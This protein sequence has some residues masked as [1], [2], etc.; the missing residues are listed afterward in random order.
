ML[1]WGPLIIAATFDQPRFGYYLSVVC[2]IGAGY[3]GSRAAG[4]V[5]GV[6]GFLVGD[7]EESYRIAR[8]TRARYVVTGQAMTSSIFQPILVW[9]NEPTGDYLY[10]S[11]GGYGY[12]RKFYRT[13]LARLHLGDGA[14]YGV[15]GERVPSI[16]HF[17]LVYESSTTVA[18]FGDRPIKRVKVFEVVPGAEVT[19]RAPDGTAA[20]ARVR[21]RTNRGRTFTYE[22]VAEA[23]DG[24]VSLTL[25][26]P[27]EGE[28]YPMKAT[29]PYE[30]VVMNASIPLSVSGEDVRT[31]ERINLAYGHAP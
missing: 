29:G 19:G 26:Y 23:K 8:D 14:D 6:A 7:E 15:Y 5:D 28:T 3:L 27:T 12:T 24:T 2:A 22:Q 20:V 9:A 13:T 31:G 30:L 18:G 21:V 16:K 4:L 25:P 17:R 10:R 11:G 1:A